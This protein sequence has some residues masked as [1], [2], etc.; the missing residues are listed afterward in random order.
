MPATARP[1][2]S[3][4][5][6]TSLLELIGEEMTLKLVENFGGTRVFVPKAMVKKH[7]VI[8]VLGEIGLALMI[9]YFSGDMPIPIARGWRIQL[10]LKQG[11]K[12]KEIARKVHC[13]E[14]AVYKHKRGE[15]IA[16]QMQMAFDES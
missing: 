11:L 8:D 14:T 15:P 7:P 4:K 12:I 2:R 9:Q 10:Y 13:S 5:E 3:L 1:E 6:L 16:A